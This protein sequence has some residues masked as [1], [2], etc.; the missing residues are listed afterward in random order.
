LK[1]TA[2]LDFNGN[3]MS[4]VNID[5]VVKILDSYSRVVVV[6]SESYYAFDVNYMKPF[7]GL[8]GMSVTI[9]SPIVDDIQGVSVNFKSI[10]DL[11][12]Q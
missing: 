11:K 2:T 12:S 8:F 9:T 5:G 1:A 3:T 4:L 6:L 7:K 10:F